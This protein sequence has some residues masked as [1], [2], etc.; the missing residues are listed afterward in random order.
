VVID[1][2]LQ[3]GLGDSSGRYG[4]RQDVSYFSWTGGHMRPADGISVQ[5]ASLLGYLGSEEIFP[6][7]VVVPNS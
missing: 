5:I 1:Q 6:C 3:A 4:S 7:L 2:V